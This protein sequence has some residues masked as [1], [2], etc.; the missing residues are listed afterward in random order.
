MSNPYNNSSMGEDE[1]SNIREEYRE[2]L[3]RYLQNMNYLLTALD[4]YLVMTVEDQKM[5]MTD[6]ISFN[7]EFEGLLRDINQDDVNGE[8]LNIKQKPALPRGYGS[9]MKDDDIGD[10][11]Y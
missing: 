10:E 2:H 11:Y 5:I 4:H 1:E 8:G 9:F 7:S 3:T 6:F